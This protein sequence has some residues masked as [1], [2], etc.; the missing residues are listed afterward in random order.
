MPYWLKRNGLSGDVDAALTGKYKSGRFNVFEFANE[1]GVPLV[2]YLTVDERI[3][4]IIAMDLYFQYDTFVSKWSRGAD[5][6]LYYM[7]HAAD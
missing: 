6:R 4:T 7:G 3:H 2:Q 1:D 5:G